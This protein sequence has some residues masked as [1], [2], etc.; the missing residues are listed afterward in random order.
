[1]PGTRRPPWL[2][3]RSLSASGVVALSTSRGTREEQLNRQM[4]QPGD[5]YASA[6]VAE[7]GHCWPGSPRPR[8]SGRTLRLR[9]H[10]HGAVVTRGMTAPTGGCGPVP[11]TSRDWWRSRRRAGGGRPAS[12]CPARPNL[13]IISRVKLSRRACPAGILGCLG[14]S[15]DRRCHSGCSAGAKP[16]DEHP[17]NSFDSGGSVSSVR[18]LSAK[19]GIAPI[20]LCGP[21]CAEFAWH[22]NLASLLSNGGAARPADNQALGESP[23]GHFGGSGRRPAAPAAAT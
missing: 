21:R 16:T 6:F 4:L 17:S 1:M 13:G 14:S 8:G 2:C 12:D 11:S 3:M 10:L 7:V 23:P 19:V 15:Y 9:R 18:A 5:P 20:L 22:G